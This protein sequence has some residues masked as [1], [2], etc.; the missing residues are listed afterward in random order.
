MCFH[1]FVVLRWQIPGSGYIFF[2]WPCDNTM[3]PVWI[4]CCAA[5]VLRWCTPCPYMSYRESSSRTVL[6]YTCPALVLC[7]LT[8]AQF[9]YC[10][11]LHVPSSR[12]VLPYTCPAP[13][14]SNLLRER[15]GYFDVLSLPRTD[16]PPLA[17]SLSNSRTTPRL[18]TPYMP[19]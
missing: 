14:T 17:L 1:L 12:T 5:C 7:S 4:L 18:C 6:P 15:F 13:W 3:Y 16:H 2:L 19:S 11:P 8:R 10:A 9:S